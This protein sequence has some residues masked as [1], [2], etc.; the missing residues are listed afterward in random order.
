MYRVV[1]LVLALT[2]APTVVRAQQ[3]CT[4]D[5]R[6]VVNE[7][8]RHV[9]ERSADPGSAHWVQQLESGRMTVR[10]V[11]REIVTSPE[12]MQRFIYTEAG[13]S[14]P[15]ERSVARL[16]RHILGR[17]PDA[18]GQRAFAEIAQRS[19]PRAVIERIL[20]SRE[21]NEQFGDWGAPGSGGVA[22]CAPSGLTSRQTSSTSSA[23][24]RRFRGMDRN[25]DGIITR[26]EWR[27]SQRSFEVH[28]WNGDGV[29][30]GA[31]VDAGAAR[32][33][34]TIEDE[35][36]DRDDQFEFLDANNN[37]RIEPREWHGS[38]AAFNRL[39]VNNDNQLSRQEFTTFG[40]AQTVPTTG[41][42]I[43]VDARQRWVDTGMTVQRGDTILFQAS[44]TVRLS[45]D[46]NDVAGVAGAF[47]GRRAPQAPLASQLA[48]AL[49]GRIGDTEFAI[50]NQGTITAPASGRLSLG[51]NDDHLAD[52]EGQFEVF[53]SVQ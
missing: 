49:I 34:R 11:V 26:R 23:A 39:D 28:D 9:L 36:L 43:A 37:G 38:V 10:E 41:N 50:G 24:A 19:G 48:G 52:N 16:Y 7:L 22:Y 29:L 46:P 45:T 15:Y 8:Y 35:D 20:N 40:G 31:E 17:Q 30:S 53:V 51:V 21:Y 4:T 2:F 12:H 6:H 25:N 33:G 42:R 44:G 27:G 32:A 13:E 14:T 5:G 18:E 47:S 3:P 1:M